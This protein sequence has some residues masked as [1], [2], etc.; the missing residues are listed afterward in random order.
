MHP[1]PRSVAVYKLIRSARTNPSVYRPVILSIIEN[2]AEN[3]EVR[4][5]AISVLP[6]TLPSSADMQ[7]L[8]IRTWFE[9]SQQ[10]ASYITS[11]LKSL[12]GLPLQAPLYQKIA[13]KAEEA[14]K[15]AKPMATGIQTS[16]NI[17]IVQFLDTLRSAVTLKLQYVNS[18]ESAVPRTM[19]VK[20]DIQSKGHSKDMFESAVYVQ[21][22]EV[23][24]EKMYNLYKI[25]QNQELPQQKQESILNIKNRM[26][27]QPEAHVTLKMLGLQRFYSIDSEF[28][29]GIVLQLTN[30]FMNDN[31]HNGFKK[32]FLKVLDLDGFNYIIPTGSGLPLYVQQRT[33][34]V[35][36]TQASLVMIKNG[37]AE[38]K[39]KP[40]I[41]HKQTTSVGVF[42]PFT[43]KFLGAGVDTSVHV[44]APLM[45]DIALKVMPYTTER[46]PI[47]ETSET[48]IIHT[49]YNEKKMMEVQLGEKIGIDLK[50][51]MESEHK[52]TDLASFVHVLSHHHP[53]TLLSLPLPLMTARSHSVSLIYNPST[54]VTKE[55]SFVMSVGYGKK[56]SAGQKSFMIYPLYQID[57][58]VE[59]QCKEEQE[60]MK[61]KFCNKEKQHCLTELRKQNRPTSEIN[62]YCSMKFYQCSQRHV[63]RQNT[64]SVLSKL[65]SGSA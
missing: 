53:L 47:Q 19:Y 14:Y 40:V 58:E 52:F 6:Y 11:T 55:A 3:E 36:S 44:A 62:K 13:Q 16:H 64:R 26:P 45:A 54:S 10:V 8:A 20:S 32:E 60:C 1:H 46:T 22:S 61:E 50:L 28:I 12:K 51:K 48:K 31:Q 38:I 39:M 65:Q 35:I 21:G 34:L 59:T 9:S 42:C 17:K 37:E 57:Q 7:K 27:K 25:V 30:E 63:S 49:S 2:I 18:E 15:L 41:N 33:P 56:P 5:A 24:M 29:Q 4:M 23:L 43:Q